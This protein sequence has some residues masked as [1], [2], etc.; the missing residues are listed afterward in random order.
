MEMVKM[1]I[2]GQEDIS[3]L[4]SSNIMDENI[5]TNIKINGDD[6]LKFNNMIFKNVDFISDLHNNC[7]EIF[8]ENCVFVDCNFKGLTNLNLINNL[9]DENN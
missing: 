7:S 5:V 1:K 6:K 9:F 4:E 8:F 2:E 3:D